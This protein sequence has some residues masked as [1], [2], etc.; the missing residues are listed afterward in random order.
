MA[1]M[2]GSDYMLLDIGSA[3]S[4]TRKR[5]EVEKVL[6]KSFSVEDCEQLR[7]RLGY[8]ALLITN[9]NQG[10][11]L[12]EKGKPPL[13]IDAVGSKEPID[14]TGAGDTVIAAYALALASGLSHSDAAKIANHAGGIVVMK[15]GT[16]T[17]TSAELC[18]S[19][20][21]VS[22]SLTSKRGM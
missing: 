7:E 12:V 19:L 9:G 3:K 16:A 18:G 22:E 10:M 13:N 21:S 14:V 20:L 1:V 17:V 15:K 2:G 5:E 6:G 8:E 4:G 11:L